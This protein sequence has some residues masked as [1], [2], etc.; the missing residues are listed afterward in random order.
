[1]LSVQNFHEL[2]CHFSVKTPLNYLEVPRGFAVSFRKSTK[3]KLKNNDSKGKW[4]TFRFQVEIVR[5]T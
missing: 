5:F 4:T 3:C 1:M 2:L